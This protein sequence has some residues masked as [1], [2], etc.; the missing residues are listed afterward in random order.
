MINDLV[1][2]PASPADLSQVNA[3]F[4]N[5][6]AAHL[7]QVGQKFGLRLDAVYLQLLLTNR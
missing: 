2:R 6:K 7:Q 4:N 5:R 1:I 3:I